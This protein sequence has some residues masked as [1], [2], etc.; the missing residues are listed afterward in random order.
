MA[1]VNI[2]AYKR[3]V[4]KAYLNI[5]D[6]IYWHNRTILRLR[7]RFYDTTLMG[8]TTEYNGNLIFKSFD[9]EWTVIKY[10][11]HV[12]KYIRKIRVLEQK[13]RYVQ[14]FMNQLTKDER[15]ALKRSLRTNKNLTDMELSFYDE[16]QEIEE[17][18]GYMLG[19]KPEMNTDHLEM[20]ELNLDDNFTE[21]IKILEENDE[22]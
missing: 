22:P 14:T 15:V 18:M 3:K 13:N 12:E 21:M 8:Y 19:I 2:N 4:M 20:Y 11:S 16:I 17:A 9:L 10:L 1:V 5:D 6:E 7:E